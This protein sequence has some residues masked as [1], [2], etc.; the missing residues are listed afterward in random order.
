MTY[1]RKGDVNS[2]GFISYSEFKLFY[3]D[4]S[5]YHGLVFVS[6]ES[7]WTQEFN[8]WD[9]NTDS[10]LTWQESW[11]QVTGSHLSDPTDEAFLPENGFDFD[12]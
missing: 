5:P 1:F 8:K 9:T 10:V 4:V 3:R 6:D 2:N 7:L 12:P 11:D